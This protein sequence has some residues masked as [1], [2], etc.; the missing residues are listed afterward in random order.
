MGRAW[1]IALWYRSPKQIAGVIGRSMT[2]PRP[3]ARLPG[4]R[5]CELSWGIRISEQR[6]AGK[7]YWKMRMARIPSCG[8]ICNQI[9]VGNASSYESDIRS[10]ANRLERIG[11]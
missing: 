6:A 5:A 2:L 7:Q 10:S 1:S 3:A 9:F 4:P 8:K 11:I